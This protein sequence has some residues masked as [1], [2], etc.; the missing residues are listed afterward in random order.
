[1][2]EP[3]K[4]V[5]KQD[6]VPEKFWIEAKHDIVEPAKNPKNRTGRSNIFGRLRNKKCL[7]V[8]VPR[9]S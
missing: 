5:E 3:G 6:R 8:L 4:Q 2:V 1:M 9:K 7:E